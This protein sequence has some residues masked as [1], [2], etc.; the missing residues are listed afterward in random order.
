MNSVHQ[1]TK[2]ELVAID[3]KVLRGSYSCEARYSTLHMVSAYSATNQLVIGQVKTQNKSNEITAIPELIKLLELKGALISIDAMGC[4]T[5]IAREIIDAGADYL[6]SVKANQKNLHRAVREALAQPLS[7]PST[8]EKGQIEQGHGRIE[9][10]QSHVIDATSLASH[11]PGWPELKTVGVTVGY[12]QEKGKSPSLEY[13][14]YISSATLTEEQFAQAV[15]SHW[16]IENTLH[17]ILD[18]AFR[19]DDCQIYHKNAPE[20]IALLRRIA[21]NMLKKETTQLSIRMKRKRAWM[22]IDFLEQVLQA[23]FSSLDDI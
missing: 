3:G 2:G 9:V 12:R 5:Q 15:R 13:R 1:L 21:L 16:Q 11:F 23:G 22:K 6:L 20:N 10:R 7:L 8:R 4:Q 17:W 14:Y 19:E 18:V